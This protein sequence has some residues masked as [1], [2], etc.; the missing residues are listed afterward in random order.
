MGRK[1]SGM[2]WLIMGSKGGRTLSSSMISAKLSSRCNALWMLAC[3]DFCF[4]LASAFS[5]RA[6]LA[7]PPRANKSAAAARC[8]LS[9][10]VSKAGRCWRIFSLS[11]R[12]KRE[13]A[14]S[15][16]AL[17]GLS[18]K[19]TSNL[20]CWLRKSV[21]LAALKSLRKSFCALIDSWVRLW[22]SNSVCWLRKSRVSLSL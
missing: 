17:E 10:W 20:A 19:A 5:N 9:P 6:R 11:I 16:T 15:R 2:S 14:I 1:L 21:F 7:S 8:L 18:D 13:A 22:Y 12:L 4:S 3:T